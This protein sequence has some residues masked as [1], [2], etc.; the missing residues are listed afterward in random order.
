MFV[1]LRPARRGLVR[2]ARALAA[3]A[4]LA[5]SA[6]L[7]LPA[8]AQAQNPPTLSSAEVGVDGGDVIQLIFSED[9]HQVPQIVPTAIVSAFTVKVDGVERQ[10]NNIVA[11]FPSQLAA[12]LSSGVYSGQT[13]VV[14][15]D[16]TVAGTNAIA[17]S[18]G[19]E[20]AS[21]TTGVAGVP[22]VVNNSNLMAPL[23]APTGFSAEAGDGEV[24]LSW[25]PPGSGS[26]VT[27]HDY[28]FRTNGSYGDWIEIDDSGPGETNASGFTVTGDIVNGRAYTFQLRAGGDDGDS[29]AAEA[30]RVTPEAPP[31]GLA[32]TVTSVVVASE[33]QSGD[34]Y[35]LHETIVFTVTFSE[36]VELKPHGRLRL[37][38]GLDDPGGGSGNSVE[39]VFSRITRSQYPT[40]DTPQVSR[41]RHMHFE[42][43]VQL[44]DRDEDGVRIGANALR[45]GSGARILNGEGG[46]DADVGPCRGRSAV[47]PQGRR[48]GGRADDRTTSRW[49]RRR[50]CG[51][52]GPGRRTPTARARTS[53]SRCEFDQPVHVEGEPTMALEVGDP[54]GSVCEARYES[55]SG[56]DTLVFAYLVLDGDID[57]NGIAIPANPIEVVYGDS[58][59]NAAGQEAHLSYR[60]EGTQ[61]G[62]KTD[63][64]RAAAPHLSVEDAEAHEA[65]G[66]MDVHGAPGA[67]RPGHRDGRL[68]DARRLGGHGRGRG[69]GLHGDERHAEVQSAGDG[70]DGD[71]AD[72]RRRPRGRRRD[73]HAE[74]VEPGRREAQGRRP[75]GQGHDPQQRPGGGGDPGSGR[76][77]GG[78]AHGVVRGHA[79]RA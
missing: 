56:T 38:V 16:K 26:D 43:K 59:R 6:A 63:G 23:S 3:V 47:R 50:G 77:G 17:D 7:T 28:R 74:A 31:M 75:R 71:G 65:D 9:L 25:D 22:A 46:G 40:D 60:R 21:F 24:T 1:R 67:A 69:R 15:Y 49:S 12:T 55:G 18:D 2:S 48:V 20:V 76:P 64:S 72:H 61:R 41:A 35:R 33:P 73:V 32:P 68:R 37:K 45:L 78:A 11:N 79:G 27:H 29:L 34:T 8:T 10:I 5:F 4:L 36:P 62:H 54:C 58:I 30:G 44:F 57:R 42:Y 66:E 14:S 52:G 51:R 13:V 19:D 53:A 70:A 39:A